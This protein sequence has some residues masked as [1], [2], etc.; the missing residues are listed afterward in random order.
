M[1]FDTLLSRPDP[2]RLIAEHW[3]APAF[4]A[5]TLALSER[6]QQQDVR[7]VALWFD[8]AARFASA[9]LAAWHAGADVYLPPNLAED[10]RA[11]AQ[12]HTGLWLTDTG[13]HFNG[14]LIRYGS[15]EESAV[16]LSVSG[17]L[18][19]AIA[20]ERQVCMKTSGSSGEAKV[21]CKTAALM[22]A[23][24]EG[25]AGFLPQWRGLAVHSSVSQQHHYGLSWRVFAALAGHWQ[26]GRMQC[27]YPET[28]MAAVKQPC[29]WV[30]SPALLNRMGDRDWA[31]LWPN[32]KGIV[33][34][35]GMLPEAVADALQTHLHFAVHDLYGS[36]ETGVL[37]GRQGTGVWT[38]LPGVSAG[39]NENGEL[40]AQAPWTGGRCQTADAVEFHSPNT[41]TLLGR[42]DRIIK[43]EDKRVSLT[44]IEHELLKHPWVADAHCALHP[45]HRRIAAWVALDDAG[46]DTLRNCGPEAVRQAL[47]QHEGRSQ[48]AVALPRYWRFAARSLP[49]NAQSKISSQSFQAAF[50]DSR[51]TPEWQPVSADDTAREYTFGGR[52]PPDL[53]YFPGH[54]P[55]FPLVP[56]VVEIRWAMELAGRFEWG[57]AD[58]EGIEN[59]KY[60]QFV[61]PD[62]EI[63]ISLRYDET[64]GKIHFSVRQGD[65]MCASGRMVQK[66]QAA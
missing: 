43:F 11:W 56:G 2:D 17:S 14:R 34:A 9:L 3:H 29:F 30:S 5:A 33:S 8:D 15:E 52:I 64:K 45:E 54:F 7:A 50:A 66:R 24:A 35:G 20:P 44:Q 16:P 12:E 6:L 19:A 22:A 37:M 57:Q 55:E 1:F 25:I 26:I 65:M 31:S 62:D 49:R 46:I 47:K 21:I 60:Q 36:T 41:L 23:E 10:N 59:L 51:A 58:L 61:R 48:D 42:T 28:L 18:K 13:E 63:T 38:L 32:L 53:A 4:A 39:T 40:W 27:L